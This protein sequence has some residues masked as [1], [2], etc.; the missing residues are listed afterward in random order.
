MFVMLHYH[1]RVL[2]V[3]LQGELLVGRA[4]LGV[5]RGYWNFSWLAEDE[6]NS[7]KAVAP[8]SG[9]HLVSV[10]LSEPLRLTDRPHHSVPK[11]RRSLYVMWRLPSALQ[12]HP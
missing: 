8:T 4:G 9:E 11:R 12:Q 5:P 3:F 7:P 2:C 10:L 6:L 1:D